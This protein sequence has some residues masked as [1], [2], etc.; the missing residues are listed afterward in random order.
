MTPM[1]RDR[2]V[3]LQASLLSLLLLA[4][5]LGVW[6]VATLQPE[7]AAATAMTA[8]QAEYAKLLGKGIGTRKTD[9]FPT[10]A[11]MGDAI[12]AAV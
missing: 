4:L 7:P 12:A 10:L 6:H 3:R 11:Q 8:E 1:K 9:G 2:L 5:F